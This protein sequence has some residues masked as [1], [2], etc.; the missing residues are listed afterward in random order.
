M[1]GTSASDIRG[2]SPCDSAVVEGRPDSG[3]LRWRGPVLWAMAVV[4]LGL[5]EFSYHYLSV[6]ASRQTQP[7]LESL[8]NEMTGALMVGL[9]FLPLRVFARRWPMTRRQ[10]PRRLPAYILALLLFAGCATSGMWGLRVLLYPLAG[11]GAFDYGVMPLRYA[12]EF[13]LQAIVFG[14]MAW[15]IQM[16]DAYRVARA[17]E[18]HAAQLE[19]ALA[20]AQLRNLRLQLQPHFL[21]NALNT[22][23][24]IM[25]RDP[26]AADE[27][28]DRIAALLRASLRTAQADEVPLAEEIET[29]GQYLAI[30]RVRFGSRLDVA[31]TLDDGIGSALV[32]SFLLQPL[33]ENAVRHGGAERL[34]TGR[35]TVRG[36]R[37]DDRLVIAVEDDGP[38]AGTRA[39]DGPPAKPGNGF[40]LRATAER[41]RLLYG[42]RQRLDAGPVAGGGFAVIVSIPFRLTGTVA[43]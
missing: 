5:L 39:A 25:Y 8:I 42:D 38:D 21:F 27:M 6:L 23:S 12:M 3:G 17:R 9:L 36:R 1:D 37:D 35:I 16:V 29:L 24:S 28:L 4:A 22:V 41:L 13:P 33:V 2:G 19:A 43:S 10:W 34:G 18:L 31:I 15:G 11:L 14:T 26:A 20:Q 32:P 40:A 7:I 30:T